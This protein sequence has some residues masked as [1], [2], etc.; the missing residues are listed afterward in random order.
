MADAGEV[1]GAAADAAP[2]IPALIG[3]GQNKQLAKGFY[4][5]AG[6]DPNAAYY[7]GTANGLQDTQNRLQQGRQAAD[8]RGAFQAN[9]GQADTDRNMNLQARGGQQQVANMMLARARGQVPSIAQMQAD[10]QMQ[11]AAAAQTSAAASAR[12]PAALALAQQ[13]AAANTAASQANISGQAQVNAAQEQQANEQNALGAFSTIRGGDAA[14]QAQSANQA[15]FQTQM[16]QANRDANDARA[17]GYEQLGERANEAALN[18]RVQNQGILAGSY[19]SA[20][21]Q[22]QQTAN[23]NAQNKGIIQTIGDF[24][25]DERTKMPALMPGAP[26]TSSF[27]PSAT[28][29]FS[30]PSSGPAQGPFDGAVT[31]SGGVSALGPIKAMNDKLISGMHD[32]TGGMLSDTRTKQAALLAKGQRQ[33]MAAAM[34]GGPSLQAMLDD[35]YHQYDDQRNAVDTSGLQGALDAQSEQDKADLDIDRQVAAQQARDAQNRSNPAVGLERI[36]QDRKFL[37]RSEVP[38]DANSQADADKGLAPGTTDFA[39][40]EP[41]PDNAPPGMATPKPWWA[42]LG[43]A[44]QK[45]NDAQFG[46]PRARADG[47]PVDAGKPYLVGERGPELV[48]PRSSGQV[49]PAEQTADV[50]PLFEPPGKELH[51]SLDGHAFF[52]DQPNASESG[53]KS[54]PA[55]VLTKGGP[56]KA[57]AA[58]PARKMS[59][60]EMMAAAEAMGARMQAEHDARMAQGPAARRLASGSPDS[61]Y[62]T[63]LTSGAEKAFRGKFGFPE[64]NEERVLGRETGGDYDLRGAFASGATDGQRFI[65]YDDGI[66]FPGHLPDTFKKPS[67]ATFSEESQYARYAPGIA[68]HWEGNQYIPRAPLWL[69]DA[70]ERPDAAPEVPVRARDRRDPDMPSNDEDWSI[71]NGDDT[72]AMVSDERAKRAAFEAGAGYATKQLTGQ[73]MTPW[74]RENFPEGTESDESADE[75]MPTEEDR[76]REQQMRAQMPSPHPLPAPPPPPMERS[77][78]QMKSFSRDP[79]ADANRSMAGSAYAYKPDFTPPDQKPGETNVGP[80]AQN[81]EQS[82]VAATAVKTDPA[83]GLKVID[84]DK[85]LKLTMA[86]IADLQRQQDQT[87]ATMQ[88]L[89]LSRGGRKR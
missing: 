41:K 21:A 52:A 78:R 23:Q 8:M 47:G 13:N 37:N 16:Q 17:M 81:M 42:A 66:A 39:S 34:K 7:G 54:A 4:G 79:I 65:K 56:A 26:S 6:Y 46:K 43:Q 5:Q 71:Q 11:Q 57:T 80:M 32:P 64:T 86:G 84:K 83:T 88:R 45:L 35:R 51:Q 72:I 27:L 38:S 33:G 2:L 30:G 82:P 22:N 12:G 28:A 44:G 55:S 62:E 68:G 73:E 40:T 24:F 61:N 50:L 53:A 85:A 63:E 9:Y 60:K 25:S 74:T 89:S 76:A 1:V 19:T 48:V 87:R 3:R 15:Q 75:Y 67:H 18:A 20:A 29:S 31:S 36:A 58:A 49:I 10:R 14:N 69:R 70:M 77:A 59:A